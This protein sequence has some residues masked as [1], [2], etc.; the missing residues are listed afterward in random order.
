MES[1][2]RADAVIVGAGIAGLAAAIALDRAGIRVK[3]VE[4]ATAHSQAGTALSLWPNA[5]VALDR[6]GLSEQIA[7]IGIE[8]PEGVIRKPSGELIVRLDQ[9]RLHERMG[10]RTLIVHRAELQ[11][12]LLEAAS[13]VPI[14]MKAPARLIFSDE[15]GGVVELEDRTHLRAP[16]ILACDGIH[17]IARSS[18]NNPT[19]KFRGR[20][21][22]RAVM[23]GVADLVTETC[24]TAGEG[25]QFI[26]SAMR[27]GLTYWAADVAL[28]EGANAGMSPAGRKAF[29]LSEFAHWHEHICELIDRMDENRLVIADFYDSVPTTLRT[30]RVALLGDAAH[31]M[32]PD[33]G[34]GACQG[35]EDA[36]VIAEC[37]GRSDD[38]EVA[39]EQ[40]ESLRLARVQRVV[41]ESRRIGVLATCSTPVLVGL[42]DLVARYMP[43]SVNGRIVARY[44]SEQSFL[45]TLPAAH[46]VEA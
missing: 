7:E 10:R 37:L 16:V 44:A 40:Y 24:L 14:V 13:H 23:E 20:T 17:T 41:R 6:I 46:P 11:R 5:L 9:S 31:P 19:P 43:T 4:R 8:E 36:V 25:K 22:W 12:V 33:L 15:N 27:G 26:V 42:R 29:L 28:P 38:P 32:T 34:Q 45:K 1:T 18:V 3:V 2:D 30:G 35:I 39:L 21:S